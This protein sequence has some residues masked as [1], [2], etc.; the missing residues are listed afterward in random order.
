MDIKGVTKHKLAEARGWEILC[1]LITDAKLTD[2]DN[3]AVKIA[4]G[5]PISQEL[6][7]KSQSQ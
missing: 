2:E 5:F 6:N 4:L 7:L 1:E 3:T